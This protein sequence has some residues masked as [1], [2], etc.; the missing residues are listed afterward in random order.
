M[1]DDNDPD[2]RIQQKLADARRLLA[3]AG[4]IADEEGFH[5]LN[6]M[7]MVFERNVGWFTPDGTLQEASEWNHSECVIGSPYA[8]GYGM[9][10]WLTPGWNDSGCTGF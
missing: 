9:R 7:G 5:D 10:G 6:F 4:K 3:E 2:R 1:T 8:E